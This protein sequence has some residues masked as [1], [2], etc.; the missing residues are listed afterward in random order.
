MG[1]AKRRVFGLVFGVILLA[2]TL[3][4]IEVLASYFVPPWPARALNPREPLRAARELAVPFRSAPWLA[5]L[6]SSWGV[7]DAERTIAKPAGEFRALFVGDSFVE[8]RFTPLA[9]PAAV[10]QRL[11]AADKIEAVNLGIGATDPR[12]YY[13]RIRDVGLELEPDAVLLFLYAG[14]DFVQPDAGYS[15]WPR[16]FDESPGGSLVGLAM[17]RTNWLMVNRLGMAD[18]F[19]SRTK[20]PANDVDVLFEAV[21]APPEERLKRIVSYAKT[22][23][24]PNVPEEKLREVLGRGNG[25]FIDIARSQKDPLEQEYLLDW[26]FGTLLSWETGDFEVVKSRADVA[27]LMGTAQVDATLSWLEATQRLLRARNIP[28]VVFLVPMGSVDPDYVEFWKPWPRAYSWNVICD[29]WTALLAA[30]L[31]KTDIRTV[32]LRP[33]LEGIPGTY[34]KMDGHWTG[35]GEA[36]VAD[37]AAAELLALR[38]RRE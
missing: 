8:S 22:Y 26:M 10:Q 31:A 15:M 23:H 11:P 19:R 1:K 18:F 9:L 3:V 14:N 21:M 36:I 30:K 24:Y 38:R 5:D 32:D 2:V 4:G 29:E 33:A 37:R 35:K 17:P 20:A 6:D 27:R 16:L 34:R 25:R 7:R 12:S 13:Y 28:L